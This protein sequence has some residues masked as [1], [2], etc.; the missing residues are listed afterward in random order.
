MVHSKTTNIHSLIVKS[1]Q[2][3]YNNPRFQFLLCGEYICECGLYAPLEDVLF[4]LS[5]I[6]KNRN[7][8]IHKTRLTRMYVSNF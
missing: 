6:F 1:S 7:H 3:D 5:S 4:F 8:L 2:H